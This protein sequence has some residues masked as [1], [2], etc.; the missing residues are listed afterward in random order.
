MP[1]KDLKGSDAR[2]VSYGMRYLIESYLMHQWTH[3]DVDRAKHFYSTHN[4]GFTPFPF[5]EVLFRKMVD[6]NRGYFPVKIQALRDGTVAH[7]HVPSYQIVAEGEY[8]RLVTFLETVLT[9]VWY[10]ST[11]A[12]LS[13]K[14]RDILASA[15]AKSV[16]DSQA[17]A[18]LLGLLPACAHRVFLADVSSSFSF[19][20]FWLSWLQLP[21]A[22]HDWRLRAPALF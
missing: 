13:R 9:H 11:V 20:R 7:I 22:G 1:Y 3:E 6:E 4:A 10:S 5:P 17:R 8:S 15:F 12:T 18:L 16:D 14:C 21:A 19:A 2:F